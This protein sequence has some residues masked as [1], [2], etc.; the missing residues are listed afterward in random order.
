MNFKLSE[1]GG[2]LVWEGDARDLLFASPSIE[3]VTATLTIVPDGGFAEF[4]AMLRYAPDEYASIRDAEPDLVKKTITTDLL[5]R[6]YTPPPPITLDDIERI[7]ANAYAAAVDRDLIEGPGWRTLVKDPPV[8][9]EEPYTIDS[10]FGLKN[11]P[12]QY[13]GYHDDKLQR[14]QESIRAMQ[15]QAMSW[16]TA[17]PTVG[18]KLPNAPKEEPV[19]TTFRVREAADKTFRSVKVTKENV[20]ELGAEIGRKLDTEVITSSDSIGVGPFSPLSTTPAVE[21]PVGTHI[22]EGWDYNRGVATFR[23]AT[24][25]ERETYDLR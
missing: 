10:L 17:N 20:R 13:G 22:V 1:D 25:E 12:Y 14:T 6:D 15:E 16:V 2:Y 8:G 23:A 3:P 24:L 7:N 4:P 21:F 18:I 19:S 5:I 11:R 9:T